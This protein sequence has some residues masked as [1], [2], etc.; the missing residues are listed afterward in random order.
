VRRP[1][2]RSTPH[3][4]PALH[5]VHDQGDEEEEEEQQQ[6]QQEE[7]AA[8]ERGP[9]AAA[10][11]ER[12]ASGAAASTSGGAG[13]SDGEAAPAPKRPKLSKLG[14]DP[15]VKTDFLPDKDRELMEEELRQKLKRVGGGGG[16]GRA[17]G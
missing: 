6:Q 15:T 10:A 2:R 17:G 13:G 11:A 5:A 3:A 8:A 9:G 14:K 16:L 12:V 1:P 7:D 4:R